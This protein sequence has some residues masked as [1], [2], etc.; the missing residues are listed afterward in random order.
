MRGKSELLLKNGTIDGYANYLS[1]SQAGFTLRL[2]PG[3]VGI[4][5]TS[6]Y[7]IQVK[8]KTKGSIISA[9]GPWHCAI[10]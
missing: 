7:Q 2:A 4:I 10:C 6:S 1:Y 5:A 8:T 9:R 3:T